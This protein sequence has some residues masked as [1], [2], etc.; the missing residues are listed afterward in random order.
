MCGHYKDLVSPPF[1]EGLGC[2]KKAVNVINNVIL[3]KVRS[4]QWRLTVSSDRPTY[5]TAR[6][7]LH[8]FRVE[9]LTDKT[10]KKKDIFNKTK[11]DIFINAVLQLGGKC[12]RAEKQSVRNYRTIKGQ[13]DCSVRGRGKGRDNWHSFRNQTNRKFIFPIKSPEITFCF[14]ETV[15]PHHIYF[16][17]ISKLTE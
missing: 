3:P 8:L 1:L 15:R 5:G 4:S 7:T 11:M 13:K 6:L 17:G 16:T 9:Q 2:S 12:K 10:K 14:R